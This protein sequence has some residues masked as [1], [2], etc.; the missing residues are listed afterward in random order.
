MATSS[1]FGNMFSV[2]GGSI[3][4]PFLPMLPIQILTNNMLYDFSQMMIP[5]DNIDEERLSK[6]KKWNFKNIKR[7]ILF[8]GSISSL[9]DYATFLVMLFVFNTWANPALFHTGWFVESLLTQTFIVHIIRTSKIPFLQSRASWPLIISTLCVIT[10][11]IYLP[12]SP[13]AK[14]FQFLP[15]PPLYFVL[16][17]IGLILYF[18]FTQFLKMWFIRKYEWIYICLKNRKNFL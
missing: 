4:L 9:F 1:N 6:P 10:V 17:F 11:G 15:L 8:F 2:V 12:F 3:F 5:T 13:F 18:L 16:L 14:A 7:F